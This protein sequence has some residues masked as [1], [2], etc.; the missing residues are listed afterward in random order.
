MKRAGKSA[1]IITF[2]IILALSYTSYFGISTKYGDTRKVYIKGF[3]D[4]VRWGIDIRG[5]VDATFKPPEG[6]DATDEQ[7]EAAKAVIAQRLVVQGITDSELYAD[8]KRDRIIVRFPWKADEVNFNPVDAIKELGE[9]AH[10]TFREGVVFDQTTG[11]PDFSA[12]KIVIEGKHVIKAT[13]G[14]DENRQ[15]IVHLELTD[16][17]GRLFEQATGRLVGQTIAIFMDDTLISNPRVEQKITGTTASITGLQ[18]HEE[19]IELA[20]KITAGALPFKLETENYSSINPTLGIGAKDIML[21]ALLIALILV[22]VF[23]IILYRLPGIIAS[24]SLIGQVAGMMAA[25]TMYFPFFPSFTLTLPGIAGI[26]LSIGMGV[27][28]N[29][30]T[31][32]RIKEELRA[33]KTVEGAIDSGFKNAF[34]AILDGNLTT[35]I[36]AVILMA[37][38]GP[39]SSL[40]SKLLSPV[41]QFF[42]PATTGAVYSFGYT[43]LIGVIF[44]FIMCVTGAKLMLKG[45]SR[46]KSLRKPTYY[47]GVK[48]D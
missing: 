11:L 8:V 7:V 38:F 26:I 4:D 44:N 29:V 25:I 23:M 10:L 36:V 1:F 46:F 30:I 28:A 34:S 39:P 47:G 32:E 12:S 48:N 31:F 45:I 18:S 9:T 22:C 33:G 37:V 5:G 6:V 27:D 13:P 15:S 40:F 24:I 19:A 35:V 21:L 41:L 43:L 42:G 20:Q 16:E 17:G 2:I 3:R 14:L